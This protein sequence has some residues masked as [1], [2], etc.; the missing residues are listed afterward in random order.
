MTLPTISGVPVGPGVVLAGKYRVERVLGQGGMGVVVAATQLD[1]GRLVALKF[2]LRS[3]TAGAEEVTRFLREARIV[4][5]LRSEHVAGVYELGQLENGAPYMAMEYLEGMDLTRLLSE[6]GPLHFSE[7]AAFVR[8]ACEAVGEAHS[9]GVVHRDLKPA[10]LFRTTRPNGAAL[11]KVLD[12]GISKSTAVTAAEQS[13][14]KTTAVLGSPYYMS[15]EQLV[16]PK[17]LDL[18]TDVWSLGVILHELVTGKVPFDGETLADLALNIHHQQLPLIASLNPEVPAAYQAVVT[19]CLQKDRELRFASVLELSA[20]LE[21]C[22]NSS[23]VRSA[24]HDELASAGPAPD[25]GVPPH[26]S[27]QPLSSSATAGGKTDGSWSEAIGVTRRSRSRV[28]LI[29]TAVGVVIIVAA[30]AATHT[31]QTESAA[32]RDVAVGVAIEPPSAAQSPIAPSSAGVPALHSAAAVNSNAPLAAIGAPDRV[33]PAPS[34]SRATPRRA[35]AT[36][37]G[38]TAPLGATAPST[39][40]SAPAPVKPSEA[41][42]GVHPPGWD[43]EML[44][45]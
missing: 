8:Q 6:Q 12:F 34:S 20:A 13:M 24:A 23:V 39:S 11:I 36:V 25:L 33:S 15:P 9:H 45:P 42:R 31:W 4:G 26:G 10:N 3:T 18:R 29:G 5:R 28:A 32:T 19:R 2:L 30:V 16:R 7:A 37:P 40:A 21:A 27:T 43:E 44:Q 1:L 38:R 22:E 17:T 35:S 41:A 14:T